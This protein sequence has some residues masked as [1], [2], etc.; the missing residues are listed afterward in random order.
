MYAEATRNVDEFDLSITNPSGMVERNHTKRYTFTTA[1]LTDS[2]NINPAASAIWLRLC[3]VLGQ[4]EGR[5]GRC[6][7]PIV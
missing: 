5:E 6:G 4:S 2:I 7:P 1:L 3:A